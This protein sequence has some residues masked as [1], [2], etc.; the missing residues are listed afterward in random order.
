MK[1][2]KIILLSIL[3][4]MI[5]LYVC[6]FSVTFSRYTE[7]FI[8][9]SGARVPN[10]IANYH[11][12]SLIRTSI[13]GEREDISINNDNS[14]IIVNDIKPQDTI[15]YKFSI[16]NQDGELKNETL[17]KVTF[18]FS[19]FLRKRSQGSSEYKDY[20]VNMLTDYTGGSSSSFDPL[21]I[22]SDI[23]FYMFDEN[24]NRQEKFADENLTGVDYSCDKI[25]VTSSDIGAT[26]VINHQI[27]FYLDIANNNLETYVFELSIKIP[28]QA[29]KPE[30][31]V[32]A[33]YVINLGVEA[34]QVLSI[35]Q[36]N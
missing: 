6:G 19:S 2:K 35:P 31:Y 20:Y 29:D 25:Y 3:F 7:Q 27:G 23:R 10:V 4:F 5:V 22:N 18:S 9:E 32:G 13:N 14:Q 1:K 8:D 33:Q 34:E 21:L 24:D 26:T 28:G 17:L 11:R 16:S 36:G 30:N 12:E 15:D